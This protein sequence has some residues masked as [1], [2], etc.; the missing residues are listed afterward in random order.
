MRASKALVRYAESDNL[1]GLISERWD[2]YER[3][4]QRSVVILLSAGWLTR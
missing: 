1:A 3:L 4:I 2:F